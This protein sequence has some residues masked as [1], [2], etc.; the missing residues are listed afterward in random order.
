MKNYP[1]SIIDD[2]SIK[3]NNEYFEK[4]HRV[5]KSYGSEIMNKIIYYCSS[6]ISMEEDYNISKSYNFGL[7]PYYYSRKFIDGSDDIVKTFY[8]LVNDYIINTCNYRFTTVD[9][10]KIKVLFLNILRILS[11]LSGPEVDTSKIIKNVNSLEL[12][13]IVVDYFDMTEQKEN[14]YKFLNDIYHKILKTYYNG[15]NPNAFLI[16]IYIVKKWLEINNVTKDNFKLYNI[17]KYN[18]LALYILDN[19][20]DINSDITNIINV[21]NEDINKMLKIFIGKELTIP[22]NNTQ[23]VTKIISSKQYSNID[24]D[25]FIYTSYIIYHPVTMRIPSLND[26]DNGNG[27]TSEFLVSKVYEDIINYMIYNH[28]VNKTYEYDDNSWNEWQQVKRAADNKTITMKNNILVINVNHFL[29]Y[30]INKLCPSSFHPSVHKKLYSENEYCHFINDKTWLNIYNVFNIDAQYIIVKEGIEINFTGNKD[31]IMDGLID[32]ASKLQM[33][34]KPLKNLWNYVYK[35]STVNKYDKYSLMFSNIDDKYSVNN[36]NTGGDLYSVFDGNFVLI[37]F[38][39][40]KYKP[41]IKT[42]YY[43]T[44]LQTWLYMNAY[45]KPIGSITE[46]L[47]NNYY[48]VAINPLLTDNYI[49]DYNDITKY[50]KTL[51][52]SNYRFN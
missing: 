45:M 21:L 34:F 12:I 44:I 8:S 27:R 39:K 24:Y 30:L 7:I 29:G 18:D 9:M 10:I 17:G 28:L 3:I 47:Y 6:F 16:E 1:S 22:E 43:R 49:Y 20:E 4:N 46:Q 36:F 5:I 41:N 14:N 23:L 42:I 48:L 2:R 33:I 51:D 26:Y 50:A 38:K 15:K 35:V 40:Y 19:E 31:D 37:D 52:L 11:G 32:W 25:L 13:Q